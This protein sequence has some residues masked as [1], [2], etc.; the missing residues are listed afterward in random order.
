MG[1]RTVVR[2][3][4]LFGVVGLL[5]GSAGEPVHFVPA[6]AADAAA[7]SAQESG[8]AAP[9]RA[10][11]LV[12][13]WNL[14]GWTG[15]TAVVDATVSITGAFDA[16]FTYDAAA[17]QF[18]TFNPTGLAFLN[19]LQEIEAGDGVWILA[20]RDAVWL[21][22]LLITGA[23]AVPLAPGF[24]L[25]M[26]TGPDDIPAEIAFAGLGADLQVAFTWDAA[27]QAFR[28]YAPGRPAFLND[29]TSLSFG[30]G[31]WLQVQR[32]LTWDQPAPPHAGSTALAS[33]RIPVMDIV[34]RP[35]PIASLIT[36]GTPAP[37][38]TTTVSGAPGAVP[39]GAGVLVAS[40]AYAMP[41]FVRADPDGSFDAE[42][43]TA[44]GDTIQIR[45]RVDRVFNPFVPGELAEKSHWP[46]T[47]VRAPQSEPASDFE[48]ASFH[49][50]EGGIVRGFASGTVSETR[51]AVGESTRVAGTIAFRIPAGAAA[52][53]A[54]SYRAE[55]SLSPLFDAAGNQV[56]AGTDFISHLRTPTGLPIERSV[57]GG[58]GL[59]PLPVTPLERV[60]DLLTGSFDGSGVV[61]EDLPDGTYRLY[62]S[63]Y[64][65]PEFSVLGFDS[66]SAA[67]NIQPTGGVISVAM[68]TVG[69]PAPPCLAPMLLTNSP[70]QGQRG[71]VARADAERIA[72]ANRI[73]TAGER[74]VIPPRDL[75]SGDLIAYRFEPFLPFVTL[76]NRLLP[77]EPTIPFDLPGGSLAVTVITPSGRSEALG[78]HTIQQA[79]TGQ[80]SSSRGILFDEGGGNP[81]SVYQLTT[82]SDDFAYPFRE[83][84]RYEIRLSGSVPDIWGTSYSLDSVFDVWVAQTLDLE[85]SSL[86]STPFEVGDRLPASLTIFPGV[87][88]AIEWDVTVYPIDGSDPV[89]RAITGTAN[90]FGYFSVPDAFPFDVAGEYL[91]TIHASYT[92]SDG[93][94]WMATRT[95]GSGIATPDGALIAHGR[96]GIDA[97]P[98]E[99]RAAWFTRSSTGLRSPGGTHI[100]FPYHSG[101]ILWQTEED[102]AQP[103]ISV[104]DTVG[105]IEALIEG[106]FDQI[107]FEDDPAQRVA[108]DA[109]PLGISTSTGLDPTIDPA[110]IDQWSYAY[111]AVERPGIRVRETVG[112]DRTNSP[113]W[114]FAEQ[115]LLQQGMGSLGELP[116]DLK[117]Q[118]GAAIFKRPDLGIGEVAI[119][120]SLWVEI[121][122]SDPRG[123]RVFPPFQG[124]AGGPTGGPI[125]TLKGEAIDL[126]I[127]PT[128]VHPGAV[129]EVGDHFVFAGQVGPP[130]ASKVTYS[131]TSP[132]GARFGGAGQAN[133]IGYYADPGGGFTVDE[134]GI[135][136]VQVDVLHDGDTSAGPVEPPYPTGGVL[137]SDG[138]S[139][140]FFVVD[141]AAPSLDA[142][143]DPFNIVQL[144][145]YGSSNCFADNQC[146]E[147]DPIHF[148]LAVPAGWTNVEADYVIRMPGFIL[149]TG[150]ATPAG[151]K[152]DA[153]YDPLR[154]KADFPNIDL[155]RRQNRR[156]GLADEIMITVYLSGRDASGAPVQAA[157]L[158]TL[159]GEDIYDLN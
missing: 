57:R 21:Q 89:T 25:E 35:P 108:L 117:W 13:G 39:S 12:P 149:E 106:R 80:A 155:F 121:A 40:L 125:L 147:V 98:V 146:V 148:F 45:Y 136:T 36:V 85:A 67:E 100:S 157:K 141:P 42:I 55:I 20:T 73:A 33:S 43:P 115:Y 1:W 11:T 110:R 61:P 74:F 128:T 145:L 38:G 116:N 123:S 60:G 92:D 94:L 151:G 142:G 24:N 104:Q 156:S 129:L 132:S 53:L 82:L 15:N 69:D 118:F 23:R 83:Y 51:L 4:V 46:G 138:G 49:T 58:Q 63:F 47:L 134:P 62:V 28:S 97:G 152:V 54:G 7:V 70:N 14:V 5:P 140:R 79:R 26:W 127:L 153:V 102:S 133:A 126:F 158:L 59:G 71:T 8:P 131:V 72:F 150:Q 66:D 78:T 87:P 143:L 109:L 124:A 16:L 19:T 64:L 139:Y 17:Q 84:G 95:W 56:S 77:E 32:D 88:A 96:R 81:G 154:L 50:V 10:V 44:P 111:R 135:W 93:T 91:S 76:A 31:V 159:V 29:L 99:A 22:P 86:P 105:V 120:A 37:D 101:D 18:R 114:R 6:S 27:A 119:Y 3:G 48:G 30:D 41:G 130:L 9:T 34:D 137:G 107:N 68:V 113:Y 122:D 2:I 112:T 65:D 103:R 52:P 75:G 90:R 144:G